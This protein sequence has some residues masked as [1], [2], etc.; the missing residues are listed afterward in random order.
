MDAM[1]HEEGEEREINHHG[2]TIKVKKTLQVL[3]CNNK[4]SIIRGYYD[5]GFFVNLCC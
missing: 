4:Y 1:R 2:K 3:L 5:R